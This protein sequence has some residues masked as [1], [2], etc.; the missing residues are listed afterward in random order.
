MNINRSFRVHYWR[1]GIAALIAAT[2]LWAPLIRP[3]ERNQSD[4]NSRSD[5][6]WCQLASEGSNRANG[7][8]PYYIAQM[9]LDRQLRIAAELGCVQRVRDALANGARV[10]AIFGGKTVLSQAILGANWIGTG[11]DPVPEVVRLLLVHGAD[12][13]RQINSD[14]SVH[15]PLYGALSRYR[16]SRPGDRQ[17]LKR[18]IELLLDFGARLPGNAARG[19]YE[20]ALKLAGSHCD[21]D[22]VKRMLGT[23]IDFSL[24]GRKGPPILVGCGKP[25]MVRL[26]LDNG[27]VITPSAVEWVLSDVNAAWKAEIAHW[28]LDEGIDPSKYNFVAYSLY[29]DELDLLKR[30]LE[31]GA[32]PNMFLHSKRIFPLA[33]AIKHGNVRTVEIL[34]EHGAEVERRNRNNVTLLEMAQQSGHEEIAHLID[35]HVRRYGEQ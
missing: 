33:Y 6:H 11:G 27:G 20:D 19:D 21:V 2:L 35:D 24:E 9:P 34:I 8:L 7:E 4:Y 5:D 17:R 23:G 28:L 31:R 15:N 32:S 3:D 29:W 10:D 25:E 12:P 16:F 1:S 13:N 14:I 22:L 26:M 18:V 30:S